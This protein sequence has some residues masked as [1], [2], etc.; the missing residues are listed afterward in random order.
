MKSK[1]LREVYTTTP[2]AKAIPGLVHVGYVEVKS[3][4]WVPLY[5]P[6]PTPDKPSINTVEGWNALAERLGQ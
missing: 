5:E 1:K 2:A 6:A 3:G 4:R